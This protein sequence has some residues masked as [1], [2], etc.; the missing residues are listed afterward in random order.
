MDD[1]AV[2]HPVLGAVAFGLVAVLSVPSVR[3]LWAKVRQRQRHQRQGASGY[4]AV[5]AL[6]ESRDGEATAESVAHFSDREA[7]V[8]A[9]ISLVLGLAASVAAAVL[10]TVYRDS[11]LGPHLSSLSRFSVWADVPAWVSDV[12]SQAK[13]QPALRETGSPI[14]IANT[15]LPT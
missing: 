4:E 14:P 7:R 2:L 6:Y 9:C 5:P 15:I 11:R 1:H 8:A 12:F 13:A 3:Q 10:L